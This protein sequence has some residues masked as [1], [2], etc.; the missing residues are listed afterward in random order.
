M[1]CKLRDYAN[2]MLEQVVPCFRNNG[3]VKFSRVHFNKYVP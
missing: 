1:I 2:N 3:I